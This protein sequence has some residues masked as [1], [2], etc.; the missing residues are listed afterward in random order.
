MITRCLEVAISAP[1]HHGYRRC[2]TPLTKPH[3]NRSVPDRHHLVPPT[4]SAA[5]P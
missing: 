3:L 2:R 4:A 1:D 5:T